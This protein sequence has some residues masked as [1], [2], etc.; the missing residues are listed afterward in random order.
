V[1]RAR[2]TPASWSALEYAAHVRDVL[3]LFERRVVQLLQGESELEVVDHDRAVA[4]GHYNDLDP[5]TV[6]EQLEAAAGALA[7]RLEGLE[8][9]DWSRTGTRAGEERTMLDIGRRAAH[10]AHHHLLDIG[11]ALRTARG[12]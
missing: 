8:P 3:E 11:R 7:V 5:A 1:L 10:E 9:D 2:P 12:R 4:E 6:L